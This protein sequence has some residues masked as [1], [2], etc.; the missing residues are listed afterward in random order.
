MGRPDDLGLY[1]KASLHCIPKKN[2]LAAWDVFSEIFGMPLR[3]AT[4]GS[5]DQKEVDRISDMMARMGQAGYAVLP[6]GTE[7][8]IVES[9]KSDAFNVYDKRVDRAN[10]EISKLIIGQTMTIEDGSSLSQ[11]QTHLKVFENLV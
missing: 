8:Q 5:R 2:V 11:S 9:A 10:S 7:I 3:T 1:L 6:T 4:T